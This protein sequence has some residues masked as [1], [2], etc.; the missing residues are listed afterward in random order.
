MRNKTNIKKY[1]GYKKYLSDLVCTVP[2]RVF[3]DRIKFNNL[4]CHVGQPTQTLM[5]SDEWSSL[6][7]S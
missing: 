2:C 4:S 6:V 3:L 1:I 7:V 5:M